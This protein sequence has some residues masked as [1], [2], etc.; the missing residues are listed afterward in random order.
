MNSAE[1]SAQPVTT[2]FID[3]V[4]PEMVTQYEAWLNRIHDDAKQFNGFVSIDVIQPQ[5]M[6][7]PEYIALVKFDH[8]QNLQN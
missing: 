1:D 8:H 6:A 3:Q 7:N 4:K 2:L 5:D